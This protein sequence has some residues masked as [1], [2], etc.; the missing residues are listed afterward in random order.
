MR[1]LSGKATATVAAPIDDCFMLLEAVD[2]YPDWYPDG[3]RDVEVLESDAAGSPSRVRARLHVSKGP[4]VKDIELVLAIE[5]Q[6]PTL[7]RL[8]R[9]TADRSEQ[10]FAITWRLRDR[11]HTHI[12]LDLSARLRVSRFLPLGGVGDKLAQG[13]V[14]AAGKALTSKRADG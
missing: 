12:E 10:Q 4:L 5:A 11:G 3:V 8:A 14:A 6:R 2:R 7:V 9:V 1:D 13:F